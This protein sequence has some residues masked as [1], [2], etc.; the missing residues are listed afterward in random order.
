MKN[1]MR[2]EGKK[3]KVGGMERMNE[4]EKNRKN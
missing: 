3:R 4:K 2:R 1:E